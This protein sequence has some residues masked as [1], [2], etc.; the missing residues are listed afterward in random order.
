MIQAQEQLYT[1]REAARLLGVSVRTIRNM[2]QAGYR[3]SGRD[4][5]YPVAVLSPQI[6]RIPARALARFVS[7]KTVT[8]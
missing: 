7:A 3:S 6:K 5:I 1:Y 4:G 8:V 2:I